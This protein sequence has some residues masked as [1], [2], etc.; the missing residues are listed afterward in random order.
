LKESNTPTTTFA[1]RNAISSL[2]RL[3]QIV[4]FILKMSISRAIQ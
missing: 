4:Y 3:L 2:L 1:I